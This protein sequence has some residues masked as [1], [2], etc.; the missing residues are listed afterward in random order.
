MHLT[1]NYCLTVTPD[2]DGSVRQRTQR[3]VTGV[4]PNV[5][6]YWIEP[7]KRIMDDLDWKYVVASYI[8]AR[9]CECLNLTQGNQSVAEYEAK[10]LRLSRYVLGIVASEYKK[11]VY[12]EDGLRDNPRVLIAPYREREFSI[13]IEKAKITE[14][15]KRAERQ[16]RGRERDYDRV[17]IMVDAIRA[18]GGNNM[19]RGERTPSRG[20]SQTEARQPALVYT[21]HHREDRDALDLIT[22]ES[23]FSEVTVLSPLGQLVQH[24]V[25]LN[26]ATKRVILR[27]EEGIKVVMVGERQNYLANVI[28]ALVAEKLVCKGG[29]GLSVFRL[30]SARDCYCYDIVLGNPQI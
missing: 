7:T 12:F 16:N 11:C 9:R 17:E 1:D 5:A 18:R 23:T 28:S 2:L 8:D 26:C 14:E 13:L 30:W 24:R 25:S 20:S 15:V 3:G 6:K 27:T 10:F 22:V 19:G 29:F 21:T 4:A